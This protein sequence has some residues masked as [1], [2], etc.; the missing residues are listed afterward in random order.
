[1]KLYKVKHNFCM[2]IFY[3]VLKKKLNNTYVNCKSLSVL[4][5]RMIQMSGRRCVNDT[6]LCVQ[7]NTLPLKKSL[8]QSS[9]KQRPVFELMGLVAVRKPESPYVVHLL[10]PRILNYVRNSE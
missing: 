8:N 5:F 2:K 7:T 6:H 9:K 1:M 3:C 4:E 10:I